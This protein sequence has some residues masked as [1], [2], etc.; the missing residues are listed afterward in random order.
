MKKIDP[1]I[2]ERIKKLLN[3]ANGTN[4]EDEASTAMRMAQEYMTKHGVSLSDLE[5]AEELKEDIVKEYVTEEDGFRSKNPERWALYLSMTVAVLCDCETYRYVRRTGTSN[6]TFVGYASDVE[7]AKVLFICFYVAIRA[8]AVNNIREAGKKRL[9]FMLG[10]SLRLLERAR[11]EKAE[12][13]KEPTGR[14]DIVVRSKQTSIKEWMKA[15]AINL[16]DTHSRA[17]H[18]QA[19]FEKGRAFG[20]TMDLMNK[21]HIK[22]GALGITHV[23]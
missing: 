8:A 19:A 2:L 9:S 23:R 10:V 18:D 5:L 21:K 13:K 14:Y 1:K 7:L 11:A 12:A 22:K 15:E 20:D 16:K 4:F 6:I 3:L 17:S